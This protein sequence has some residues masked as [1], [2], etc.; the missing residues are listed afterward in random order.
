MR[1][2][3]CTGSRTQAS[4]HKPSRPPRGGT[5]AGTDALCSGSPREPFLRRDGDL[6]KRS[7]ALRVLRDQ[8]KPP[9][10]ARFQETTEK[11]VGQS[12]HAGRRRRKGPRRSAWEAAPALHHTPHM[13][14]STWEHVTPAHLRAPEVQ[15]DRPPTST[16]GMK[17]GTPITSQKSS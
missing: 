12:S 7:E 4:D 16:S 2:P 3:V 1:G 10:P 15:L 9:K 13:T 5:T 8:E 6:A 17:A 14:A 11:T